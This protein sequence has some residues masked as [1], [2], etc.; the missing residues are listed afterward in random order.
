MDGVLIQMSQRYQILDPRRII[1]GQRRG[2]RIEWPVSSRTHLKFRALLEE[3]VG[4]EQEPEGPE[5]EAR[6]EALRE[7]IRHL[8][9]FPQRFH[10]VD[11]TIVPVV[12]SVQR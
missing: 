8:P 3:L 2:R 10:P 1:R 6:A 7:D 4:L 9:G 12:T 11:D 5:R